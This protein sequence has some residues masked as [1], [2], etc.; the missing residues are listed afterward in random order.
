M[1]S[2]HILL[3]KSIP[4]FTDEK[5][6]AKSE[7]QDIGCPEK[8]LVSS[9]DVA[10]TE[11]E[12]IYTLLQAFDTALKTKQHFIFLITYFYSL[13][14]RKVSVHNELELLKICSLPQMVLESL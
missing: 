5:T 4:H 9:Y 13:Y 7:T 3:R 6:E 14:F 12:S 8:C 1:L 10:S 11:T 2:N